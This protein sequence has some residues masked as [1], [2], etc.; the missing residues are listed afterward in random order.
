MSDIT[1]DFTHTVF[2]WLKNPED[3]G[4]RAKFETAIKQFLNDSL[5]A[6]SSHVGTPAVA[7]RDVIDSSY[8]YSL[9]VTF[10]S[11]AEHDKYQVEEAHQVFIETCK[12]LWERVLVYDSEAV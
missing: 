2:F 6:K 7:E 3:S 1:K 10:P 4:L 9:L 5:Y 11:K 8:T 12:D